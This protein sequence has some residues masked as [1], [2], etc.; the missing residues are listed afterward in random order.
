MG[1]HPNP[2]PTSSRSNG[3]GHLPSCPPQ[4]PPSA[5]HPGQGVPVYG[6]C[7]LNNGGYTQL[8]HHSCN[9]S[10]KVSLLYLL[11]LDALTH[12]LSLSLSHSH[13]HSHTYTYTC[14][15][16]HVFTECVIGVRCT[17]APWPAGVLILCHVCPKSVPP[18]GAGNAP[19]L[20]DIMIALCS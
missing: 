7:A 2:T 14:H 17:P 18:S 1:V 16:V 8:S 13:A 10:Q 5:N 4:E 15:Q 6:H 12:S 3:H 11:K 9:R 19:L 20:S